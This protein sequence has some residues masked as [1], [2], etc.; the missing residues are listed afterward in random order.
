MIPFIIAEIG[1]NA[2]GSVELAKKLIDMAK[3][4]GADAVKFQ[5]RTIDTVYTKEFLDSPRES[6]WGT[7]QRAQKE[8]I[9]FGFREYD[10]IDAYCKGVGIKWFASA[11]DL[12]SQNFLR[13]FD[14]LYNK[15]ASP[16]LTHF[17]LLKMVAAEG[18]PTF[19]STGMSTY[20]QIDA[21]VDIFIKAN[22][23]FTLMHTTSTYPCRDEDTNLL[24]IPQLRRRYKCPVGYS[25]HEVGILPSILAVALGAVAIER[26]I[27]LDRSSY[28]S[29]QAASL[30]RAGLE[31]L[32]RDARM[33]AVNLG[34]GVKRVLDSER[35]AEKS[36]RYWI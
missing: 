11:W 20:E 29:D 13:M 17:P 19:I 31:R 18:K 7:A 24:V 27:S 22:C 5:K 1:I 34:D 9:E 35:K 10:E 8:G 21:A 25:G 3:A 32:V 36:L 6:P 2:N 14:L 28:G 33:V 4:C 16:M 15:I 30:E 23:F 12:E 26:H